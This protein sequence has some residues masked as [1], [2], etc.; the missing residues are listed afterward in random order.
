MDPM[1][2][3]ADAILAPIPLGPVSTSLAEVPVECDPPL[4]G[5][6]RGVL[7]RRTIP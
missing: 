4:A 6:D 1:A 7:A 3:I 5:Y 2:A